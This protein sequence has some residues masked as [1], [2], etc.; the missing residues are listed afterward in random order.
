V[1]CDTRYDYLGFDLSPGT[2]AFVP[3]DHQVIDVDEGR[4]KLT[5]RLGLVSRGTGEFALQRDGNLLG[6]ATRTFDRREVAGV[7]LTQGLELP[8]PTSIAAFRVTVTMAITRVDQDSWVRLA[9][10]NTI[11]QRYDT[12]MELR[13]TDDALHTYSF[14]TT[15][16]AHVDRAGVMRLEV[17]GDLS[18]GA[19]AELLID[20]IAVEVRAQRQ[21]PP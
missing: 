13:P 3:P 4:G 19:Q 18:E 8:D 21:P 20:G 2:A 16:L 7:L 17:I 15:S 9:I 5:M 14:S 1:F 10:R 11:L 6:V 12:V